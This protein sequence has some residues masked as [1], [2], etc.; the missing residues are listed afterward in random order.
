MLKPA[1]LLWIMCVLLL[2]T[3]PPAQAQT[4]PI[5][6]LDTG[7]HTAVIKD[8]TFTSDGRY[9][10]SAGDDKVVRIWDV[11]Q[12][13]T[14][15]TLRGEISSS[16]H[17]KIFALA[18]SP[19][20]RLLAVGGWMSPANAE[21]PCCG[22]IR[23]FDFTTGRLVKRLQGHEG[24]VYDLAFSPDGSRLVSAAGDARAFIWDVSAG[25]ITHR[26]DG[27]DDSVN[28]A[29]FAG[30]AAVITGSLDGTVRLWS[31]NDGKEIEAIGNKGSRIMALAVT[32]DATRLAVGEESGR[33][34][35][36]DI[37]SSPV[38]PLGGMAFNW[39]IGALAFSPDQRHLIAT[40]GY[41]CA[42]HPEQ[43]VI[44]TA[45]GQRRTV[46]Q[47]HDNSV[48]ALAVH[49]KGR[50]VATAGGN[51]HQVHIWDLATGRV[52]AELGGIG[53]AVWS[54]ATNDPGDLISWGTKDPCPGE[55]SCPRSFG[56][57]G[58]ELRL[59]DSTSPLW[60]PKS[61]DTDASSLRRAKTDIRN[62]RLREKAGGDL[63]R[64]DATLEV[65][66]GD[67]VIARIRRDST[68]GI[69]HTAFSFIRGLQGI[70]SGGAHG[71]LNLYRRPFGDPDIA[72]KGHTNQVWA[73]A[74]SRD[75]KLLVSGSADQ[76]VR[77]WNIETGELIVSIFNGDGGKWVMWTPQG[78]YASSA[79]GDSLVGWHINQGPDK[80]A[81]FVT[82]QQL[83]RHLYSPEIIRRAL[84]L[85]SASAA[86]RELRGTDRQ[87]ENLLARPAPSI[88][89]T[90]PKQGAT[91]TTNII[92][93]DV[94]FLSDP[95]KLKTLRVIVNNRNITP[96][97]PRGFLQNGTFE[98]TRGLAPAADI[99]ARTAFDITLEPGANRIVVTA[100]DDL[101]KIAEVVVQIDARIN[102]APERKGTLHIAAIGV[103]RY[104]FLPKIC[105]G[106]NGSCD[107]KFAGADARFFS[108]VAGRTVGAGFNKTRL[109]RMVDGE[110]ME[111]TARNIRREL[112]EFF[113]AAEPEDTTMLFISGHG[114]R[115]DGQE[116][117]YFLP[118]DARRTLEDGK[119]RWDKRSIVNWRSLR[120][121]LADANG[122]RI[123][124]VDTCHAAAAW[125]VANDKLEKQARD[126]EVIVFSATKADSV[127]VEIAALGHGAF[128]HALLEGLRGG[129]D[130]SRDSVI[131]LLELGQFVDDRVRA[132]TAKQQVPIFYMS[133][134]ENFAIVRP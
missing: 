72:F 121:A 90:E 22:D 56:D 79:D 61:L 18:L 99:L 9:V 13:R 104:P 47:G 112:E 64:P 19:D 127:A 91:V 17:G 33:L 77:L 28:R 111:P 113:L 27:H 39:L 11:E 74:A 95:D 124:F 3:P 14:V 54:V 51:R 58:W 85:K 6:D 43:V 16:H 75:G 62:L 24:P 82:A 107:L 60:S 115:P 63:N 1:R 86:A 88:L 35:L 117:Y 131:S 5:L 10:V 50:L 134:I 26:L 78:Y 65:L 20:D 68:N 31:A 100:I 70:V 76:T 125:Y 49:P 130:L 132:V 15:R 114:I 23:I 45:T 36:W 8:I 25:V 71:V 29:I 120:Q 2:S 119:P 126:S 4:N 69:G 118:K 73:V 87:L 109:L 123:M 7:G 38:T 116:R 34:S 66:R 98:A 52:E 83:R 92:P 30:N 96:K 122:R 89:I 102:P 53:R 48:R 110:T 55:T 46:Y 129:A 40:C 67:G 12:R 81:R 103:N 93:L 57:L 44:D 32:G 41:R 21:R 42:D 106:P 108:D 97:H 105:A 84:I 80:E 101:D 59:P 133:G 128:T 94:G 37:S